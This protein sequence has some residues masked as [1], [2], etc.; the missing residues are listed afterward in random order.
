MPHLLELAVMMRLPPPLDVLSLGLPSV[1]SPGLAKP[2][3]TLFLFH[4]AKSNTCWDAMAGFSLRLK[5]LPVALFQW[6][7]PLARMLLFD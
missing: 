5:T 6:R 1:A 3:S 4:E 7:T 2:P